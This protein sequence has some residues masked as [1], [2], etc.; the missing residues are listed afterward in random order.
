MA[1]EEGKGIVIFGRACRTEKAKA[2]CMCS[3]QYNPAFS[4]QTAAV[5]I[6]YKASGGSISEEDAF[7]L[8]DP[9]GEISNIELLE[10]ELRQEMRLPP[11]AVVYF[12]MYDSRRDVLKVSLDQRKTEKLKFNASIGRQEPEAVCGIPLRG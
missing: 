7:R 4:N 6:V 5:F 8:L 3:S 1:V 9:L 10:E 11:A 2:N 12:K